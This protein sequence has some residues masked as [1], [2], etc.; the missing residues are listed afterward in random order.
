MRGN[1]SRKEDV[2]L[3][4]WQTH[5][6]SGVVAGYMIT[7]GDWKG[8]LIGGIAGILPDLDEP[9]SKFGKILIPVSLPLNQLVGHRTL[10]HSL[11]FAIATGLSLSLFFNMNVG[12]AFAAGVLAHA[13]GDMLTGRVKLFYPFNLSVGMKVSPFVFFVND[14][15]C[16]VAMVLMLLFFGWK[17]FTDYF[18]SLAN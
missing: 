14:R 15:I 1:L 13:A 7:G 8:G 16:R 11:L 4:E 2:L 18:L 9:K 10:T 17:D 5:M 12:L 6:L 3:M